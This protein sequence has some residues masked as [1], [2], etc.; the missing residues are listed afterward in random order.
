MMDKRPRQNTGNHPDPLSDRW[1]WRNCRSIGL[2]VEFWP[3][4]WLLEAKRLED[5]HGGEMW[6]HAGPF[7]LT[8]AY[9]A[10]P[11]TDIKP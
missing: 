7:G 11:Q 2:K 1:F 10:L 8:I 9:H 3:L 6:I 5:Q 4:E